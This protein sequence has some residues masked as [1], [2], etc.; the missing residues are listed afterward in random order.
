M[1]VLATLPRTTL[2]SAYGR[3][4]SYRPGARAE[5]SN[6]EHVSAARQMPISQVP[7]RRKS[8]QPPEPAISNSRFALASCP[9]S[10]YKSA[11]VQRQVG[12]FGKRSTKACIGSSISSRRPWR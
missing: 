4:S 11:S 10:Q 8:V 5:S 6:R 3:S 9:S 7:S 1:P 2:R 12:R